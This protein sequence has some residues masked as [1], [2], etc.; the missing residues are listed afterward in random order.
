M[1]PE[2]TKI[3]AIKTFCNLQRIKA[4]NNGHENKELDYQIKEA[5]V[6]LNSLNISVE[7]LTL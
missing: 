3:E 5:T 2:E 4:A 1:I 7:E 6:Q